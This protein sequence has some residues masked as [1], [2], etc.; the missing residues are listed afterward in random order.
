MLV[1]RIVSGPQE[2]SIAWA[3]ALFAVTG[4]DLQCGSKRSAAGIT[5][6]GESQGP[7]PGRYV[8]LSPEILSEAQGKSDG[9]QV[10]LQFMCG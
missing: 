7:P 1:T 3:A 4:T 6:G 2:T 10:G 5:K 9:S 8:K